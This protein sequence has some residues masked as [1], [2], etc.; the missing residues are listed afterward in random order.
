M[1]RMEMNETWGFDLFSAWVQTQSKTGLNLAQFH[2]TSKLR[3]RG[4]AVPVAMARWPTVHPGRSSFGSPS[5]YIRCALETIKYSTR[6]STWAMSWRVQDLSPSR[7]SLT[8]PTGGPWTGASEIQYRKSNSPFLTFLS[9]AKANHS[10]DL[11][12]KKGGGRDR[13]PR[14]QASLPSKV[15]LNLS[16]HPSTLKSLKLPHLASIHFHQSVDSN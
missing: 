3:T 4:E 16:V 13:Y 12:K 5:P 9:W 15:Y 10:E 7:Y 2:V 11:Y 6:H 1:D 14:C 8:H